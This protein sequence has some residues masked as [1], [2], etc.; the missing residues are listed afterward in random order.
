[1]LKPSATKVAAQTE[2]ERLIA[3][4]KAKGGVIA[5]TKPGVGQGLR[6]RKYLK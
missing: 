1:M 2:T 6:K 5:T 3:E 4:F